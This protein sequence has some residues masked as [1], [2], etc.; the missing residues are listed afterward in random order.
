MRGF[1]RVLPW[2]LLFALVRPLRAED[3]DPT[4][5]DTA[6]AIARNGAEYF[7]RGEWDKAREHF[8][9]AYQLVPAPTLLL[10]EARALVRLGR[11]VDA[12]SAY[13]RAAHA[14]LDARPNEAYRR[15]AEEAETELAAL[16]PRVPAV[17][18]VSH[19]PI[20]ELRLDGVAI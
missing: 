15:A 3:D 11:L 10:M 17:R 16:T 12:E 14:P 1:V 7:D 5:R 4:L 8:H 19:D 2:V 13:A 18:I 20:A 6:R 9:R